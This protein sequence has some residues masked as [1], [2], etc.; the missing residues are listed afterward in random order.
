MQ[1][2]YNQWAEKQKAM[3]RRIPETTA[4]VFGTKAHEALE[5]IQPKCDC[6][7]GEPKVAMTPS[8]LYEQVTPIIYNP[9]CMMHGQ[10]GI[11]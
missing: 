2:Q 6:T 11:S 4:P 3:G 7:K 1:E 5:A 8:G 10:V 9:E